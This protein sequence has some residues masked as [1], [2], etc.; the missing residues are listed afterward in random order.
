[1]RKNYDVYLQLV[2]IAKEIH[3]RRKALGL[4]L[5]QVAASAGT[6]ISTLS[7]LEAGDGRVA[8]QTVLACMHALE[9]SERLLTP[10]TI[11]RERAR[12]FTDKDLAF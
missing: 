3:N 8:L 12:V 2:D 4:S 7:R 1:M 10:A 11:E 6:S 9:L 5:Q